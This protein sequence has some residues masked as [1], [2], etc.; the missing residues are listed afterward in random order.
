MNLL[1]K[2]NHNR[3]NL[4][5]FD[6]SALRDVLNG[7]FGKIHWM[8]Y[9]FTDRWFADPFILSVSDDEITVL[10]EELSYAINRGRLAKLIVDRHTYN[11]KEYKIILDKNTHMS[12]PMILRDGNDVVIIPENSAS[13]E[14]TAYRYNVKNDEL[15]EIAVVCDKPLADATVFDIGDRSFMFA[16]SQPDSNGRTLEIFNFDKSQLNATPHSVVEFSA[17]IARNAGKPFLFDG[18]LVRPAQDCDGAY[19]KGVILQEI[20][21]SEK[22]DKF[23]FIEIGKIYPFSFKYNLGLHTLNYHQGLFVIDGRGFLY[24]LIGRVVRPVINFLKR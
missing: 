1:K 3:W 2:Y 14:C 6:E 16:T 22:M 5:F 18:K 15:T 8:E 24:P 20:D 4:A 10:V 11:L 19:G 12:F 23:Q 13:G 9:D 21:Y 17:P 7:E